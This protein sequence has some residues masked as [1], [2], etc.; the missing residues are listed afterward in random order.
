MNRRV[1]AVLGGAQFLMVLDSSVM[2]VS[3]D[4]LVVD[5]DTSVAAIQAVITFYALVM[6]ALMTTG[7]KLGDL[8]VVAA[9]APSAWRSTHAVRR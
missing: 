3:I 8:W 5:F 2:N 9:C 4:Q 6:A 7:G 1:L